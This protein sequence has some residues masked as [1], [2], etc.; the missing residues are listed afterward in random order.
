MNKFILYGFLSPSSVHRTSEVLCRT[1]EAV[2][3]CRFE[4][5]DRTVDE[6]V[7]LQVCTVLLHCIICEGGGLMTDGAVWLCV[8]TCYDIS[9]TDS[10]SD[11]VC[12]H[13]EDVLM[14]MVLSVFKN[15]AQKQEAAEALKKRP[16]LQYKGSASWAASGVGGRSS[17]SLAGDLAG[18]DGSGRS[19]PIKETNSAE[20]EA[21]KEEALGMDPPALGI[22]EGRDPYSSQCLL[23]LTRWLLSLVNPQTNTEQKRAF[24]LTLVNVALETG[25]RMVGTV[26]AIVAVIGHDLCKFLL[27]NTQTEDVTILSLTLR[28]IFNLF[29]SSLKVH[30]KVQLEV[31]F[32]TIHLR[33]PAAGKDNVAAYEKKEL[34]LE[35]VVEFCSEPDLMVDLYTNYDA[36][37]EGSN[38]F[39]QL[40]QFLAAGTAA[41]PG[42]YSTIHQ[43]SLDGGVALV[44]SI[45]QRFCNPATAAER[46]RRSSSAEEP[47]E[48]GED[49]EKQE[50]Q[51]NAMAAKAFN[52]NPR[53][54][55]PHLVGLGV[56]DDEADAQQVAAFCRQ[57]PGVDKTIL[58]DYLGKVSADFNKKVLKEFVQTFD[59]TGTTLNEALRVFLCS[60][61]LPGEAQ[62]VDLIMETFAGRWYEGNSEKMKHQDT[63]FIVAFSI[64][65]LNTDLH[66]D[67]I[68]PE[69]K[70]T[71]EQYI[72]MNRGIDVG[73]A[74]VPEELLRGI[75]DDIKNNEIKMKPETKTV[76][77]ELDEMDDDRWAALLRSNSTQMRSSSAATSVSVGSEMF[78]TIVEP[79]VG[80]LCA[81]LDATLESVVGVQQERVVFKIM[82]GVRRICAIADFYK[83]PDVVNRCLSLMCKSLESQI[84]ALSEALGQSSAATVFRGAGKLVLQL[85]NAVF[86]LAFEHI[87]TLGT[88]WRSLLRC[89]L[90][91][92][93]GHLK[94]LPSRLVELDD[95]VDPSGR[96]LPSTVA[97]LQNPVEEGATGG[98]TSGLTVSFF[99][100]IW[101]EEA[102]EEEQAKKQEEDVQAL[103]HAKVLASQCHIEELF[104]KS[105]DLP[106]ETVKYLIDA[107][108]RGSGGSGCVVDDT[109]PESPRPTT[110]REMLND[111]LLCRVYSLE[112]LTNVVANNENRFD[113][114]WPFVSQHFEDGIASVAST[115]ANPGEGAQ[116]S[117]LVERYVVSVLR[118]CTMFN[119]CEAVDTVLA[120]LRPLR[121]ESLSASQAEILGERVTSGLL[122]MLK[123]NGPHIRQQQTWELVF[124]LC[125]MYA[126][127]P[128]PIASAAALEAV[129]HLVTD[130][131]RY[132]PL[133]VLSLAI[134]VSCEFHDM[135][136]PTI[137]P[138]P[139]AAAGADADKSDEERSNSMV[140]LRLLVS[141]LGGLAAHAEAATEPVKQLIDAH[142]ADGTEKAAAAAASAVGVVEG[143]ALAA[144]VPLAQQ[145]LQAIA[146]M[147]LDARPAERAAAFGELQKLVLAAEGAGLGTAAGLSWLLEEL[148]YGL[149]RR[150][151]AVTRAED[152][153]R[154]RSFNLVAQLL[155]QPQQLARLEQAGAAE[156]TRV[157]DGFLGFVEGYLL[158]GAGRTEEGQQMRPHDA[159][160]RAAIEQSL[161][162]TLKS[163]WGSGGGA[164]V[165]PQGQTELRAKTQEALARW[166]PHLAQELGSELEA[167]AAAAPPAAAPV[168]A[169]QGD[170]RAR[171]CCLWHSRLAV[172]R[173]LCLWQ[174][175]AEGAAPA[176]DATEPKAEQDED[177]VRARPFPLASV[178]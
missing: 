58:G 10:L 107:L 137:D 11:I 138:Y 129:Q 114:V 97:L 113:E 79:L 94:L 163:L 98:D 151:A 123:L 141:L 157:W 115:P 8:K 92:N 117:L 161:G 6:Q 37:I 154:V 34:V 91:M 1:V 178:L 147:C 7:Y 55:L 145:A 88:S 57:C 51:R 39:E 130:L 156:L 170:V 121:S 125:R 23:W 76:A 42:E 84:G 172:S 26:P 3:Q 142:G 21:E 95:F 36:D 80:S 149:L 174:A 99:N 102:G 82:Q 46:Q 89:V 120:T 74:N 19:E 146:E 109:E 38:L 119:E 31:F 49:K 61:R 68:K 5:I 108:M 69:R 158:C 63:A 90:K 45:W 66:N 177:D 65:M 78:K 116:P 43:L 44:D 27:Q 33:I 143:A 134:E 136:D 60:F 148:L 152:E 54:S 150:I 100:M 153:L 168:S 64:I 176:E 173:R 101:G 52:E 86:S 160:V 30:L 169:A 131:A 105:R 118:I 159:A 13:A 171:P 132:L 110:Q 73:G 165:S 56:I 25:A 35:S 20:K 106:L 4:S 155:L 85:V 41:A 22:G 12:R 32:N 111:E 166:G 126:H 104:S 175:K 133:P 128:R 62:Q 24:G 18:A 164:G 40:G 67:N 75:Y 77:S 144:V 71:V 48:G 50:K 162:N 122:M 93:S 47:G 96:P 72:N 15:V 28:V 59:F 9:T 87:N 14:Q 124:E 53:K 140:V 17:P 103:S 29:N 2:S 139:A 83:L 112:W 70:M 81:G 127:H 167:A 135:P 16:K